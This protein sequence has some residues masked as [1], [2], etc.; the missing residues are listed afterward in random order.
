MMASVSSRTLFVT[1]DRPARRSREPNPLDGVE[2]GTV[3]RQQRQGDVVGDGE[4]ALVAANRRRRTSWACAS[5]S[6]VSAKCARNR[7]MTLALTLGITRVTSSPVSG[8]TAREDVGPLV[9]DLTRPGGTLAHIACATTGD[10]PGPC[11]RR[12]LHP[13][14]VSCRRLSGCAAGGRLQDVA[15]PPFLKRSCASASLR[16]WL[17]RAF[18]RENPIRRRTRSC[19]RGGRSW[20]S[21]PPASGTDRP[22]SRRNPVALRLRPGDDDRRQ[23]RFLVCRQPPRRVALWTVVKPLQSLCIVTNNRVAKRLAIHPRKPARHQPGASP[24]KHSRSHRP[25]PPLDRTI[26]RESQRRSSK[27]VKSSRILSADLP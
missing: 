17:G 25:A 22:G 14:T 12:A 5:W 8:R 13:E 23:R 7:S 11:C 4:G 21:A 9:A 3:R 19:S 27:G 16:G 24:P 18:W 15:K 6:R 1:S 26:P 2:F 10:T 20:R